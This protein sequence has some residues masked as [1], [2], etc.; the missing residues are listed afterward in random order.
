[1]SEQVR[2]TKKQKQLLTF[3]Q[4]FIAV[5]GYGPSYRE[6][7]KGVGYNS[8]ASVALHVNNLIARGHLRKKNNSARSIE[9]VSEAATV[10][11]SI[12]TNAVNASEEKWLISHI[13]YKFSQAE[14][15]SPSQSEVDGLY[16]L[17]GALK[18]LGLS[19][20]A[21]SFIPRLSEIKSKL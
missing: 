9:V 1:M 16:V 10:K 12:P 4:E 3:I 11:S 7:M 21:N 6:I 17:V 8:P 14:N 18:V 13:E 19:G 20:A 15:G 2:P 5:H